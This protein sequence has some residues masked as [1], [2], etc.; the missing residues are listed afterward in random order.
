MSDNTPTEVFH[1]PE[2]Q[3]GDGGAPKKSKKLVLIL[4]ILGGV[5]LVAV[6]I[7]L[8]LLFSRAFSSPSDD[9]VA[10]PEVSASPSETPSAS[11]SETPNASP[12]ETPSASPSAPAPS[13]P[14][15]NTAINS[16]T[17]SSTSV[18]CNTQAQ[19]PQPIYLTFKWKTTNVSQV[20][21]G[22][23]S[24]DGISQG[25]GFNLPPSGN[26]TD[27]FPAGQNVIEFPCPS[28]SQF[29]TLTVI[30]PDGK[31]SKSV[32]VTNNGDR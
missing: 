5:L 25:M 8:T 9:V 13:P 12:S 3:N 21:F 14:S 18:L 22:V 23:A 6:I 30:G 20:G 7:L 10:T 31:I 24:S 29:Y 11:P 28:A 1:Q 15:N 27:D 17:A 32:T 26:S 4:S 2:P 16:F 19:V